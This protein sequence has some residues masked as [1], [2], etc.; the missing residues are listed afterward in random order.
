MTEDYDIFYFVLFTAYYYYILD[1]F[2]ILS[3]EINKASDK[4]VVD[5]YLSYN[6][7]TEKL[8]N[9]LT[10]YRDTIREIRDTN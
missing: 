4:K 1:T 3:F 9:Q 5:F 6:R 8:T 2:Y 7:V 10:K